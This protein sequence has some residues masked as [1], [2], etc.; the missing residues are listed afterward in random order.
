MCLIKPLVTVMFIKLKVWQ[1]WL[2]MQSKPKP[3]KMQQAFTQN[4]A[5][6]GQNAAASAMAQLASVPNLTD[7]QKQATA[8]SAATYAVMSKYHNTAAPYCMATARTFFSQF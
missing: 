5:L 3:K 4:I 2:I 7:A 6:I 1:Q 8:Q